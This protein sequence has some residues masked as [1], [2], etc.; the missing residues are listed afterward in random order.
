M[1]QQ[2]SPVDVRFPKKK[3]RNEQKSACVQDHHGY[4][5]QILCCSHP[6]IAAIWGCSSIH[7]LQYIGETMVLTADPSSQSLDMGYPW[8]SIFPSST[9]MGLSEIQYPTIQ[10]FSFAHSYKITTFGG[11]PIFSPKNI[12]LE[13]LSPHSV[14][15]SL[16]ILSS[17]IIVHR[18]H[19]FTSNSR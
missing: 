3:R 10:W 8:I 6:K 19:P 13:L 7:L 18:F 11:I 16:D 2:L 5:S 14:L 12:L 4:G 17:K 15:I 1:I 9:N